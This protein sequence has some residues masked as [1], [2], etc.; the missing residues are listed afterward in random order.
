MLTL[1][2]SLA[3]CVN[4]QLGSVVQLTFHQQVADMRL[5]R[6]YADMQLLAD[7]LIGFTFGNKEQDLLLTFG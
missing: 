2:P 1:R 5:D 7:V 4:G 6:L 3:V